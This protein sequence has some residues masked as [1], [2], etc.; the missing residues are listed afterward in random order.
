MLK[1]GTFDDIFCFDQTNVVVRIFKCELVFQV[2]Y[3]ESRIVKIQ[4][5]EIWIT[6][7][8]FCF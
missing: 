4:N 1:L 7:S 5:R 8:T 3:E 2:K 6:S